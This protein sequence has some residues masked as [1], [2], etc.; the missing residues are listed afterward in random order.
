MLINIAYIRYEKCSRFNVGG[1]FKI[2]KLLTFKH[3]NGTVYVPINKLTSIKLLVNGD[4]EIQS[5]N[6]YWVIKG[7]C[8]K[9][10]EQTV[11]EIINYIFSDDTPTNMICLDN[12]LAISERRKLN[13]LY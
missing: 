9:F 13:E 6:N 8:K 7:K 1:L 4:L 12:I 11:D 10:K 2:M 3:N 5:Q